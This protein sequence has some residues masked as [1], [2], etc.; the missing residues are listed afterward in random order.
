MRYQPAEEDIITSEESAGLRTIRDDP[1]SARRGR[2]IT[3]AEDDEKV[4][5]D[6][7]PATMDV[8]PK[9][10]TEDQSDGLAICPDHE[11]QHVVGSM[12]VILYNIP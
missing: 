5:R 6:V 2:W 12:S 3:Y 10:D 9:D 8:A 1:I 11:A 7:T 4:K